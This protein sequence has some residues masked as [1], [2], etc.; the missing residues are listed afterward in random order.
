[1]KNQIRKNIKKLRNNLNRKE[2][3]EKSLSCYNT[4][5]NLNIY[6]E[7][8]NIMSYMSIQ[9]EID[10]EMINN[11]ILNDNK[12]LILPAIVNGEIEAKI[13]EKNKNLIKGL[14]NILEPDS[15]RYLGKID[16]VLVPGLAFD[17]KGDRIGFGKGY[18]DRF[19]KNR[20]SIKI[21]IGYNFQLLEDYIDTNKNDISMDYLIIEDKIIK[22]GT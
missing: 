18:Y 4:F 17:K 3:L 13:C 9:N 19:L 11:K 7:S 12:S 10:T 8:I 5:F 21:G 6:K 16:I 22:C 2:I 14:Y 15:N 20:N 1:M